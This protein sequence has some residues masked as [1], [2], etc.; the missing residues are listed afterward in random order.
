MLLQERLDGTAVARPI[1]FVANKVVIERADV[2]VSGPENTGLT[3]QRFDH[4][5]NLRPGASWLHRAAQSHAPRVQILR[6]LLQS[7]GELLQR[8]RLAVPIGGMG[9]GVMFLC[10][11]RL[12][13]EFSDPIAALEQ[14][15]RGCVRL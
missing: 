6:V 4:Q 2:Y 8:Y 7:P 1:F 14:E 11:S 9:T 10:F 12:I 3:P 13:R 15:Y 5:G